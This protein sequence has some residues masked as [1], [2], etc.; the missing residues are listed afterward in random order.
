MA[1]SKLTRQCNWCSSHIYIED[2]KKDITDK[3]V[4]GR[5]HLTMK[6]PTCNEEVEIIVRMVPKAEKKRD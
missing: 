1:F 2:R 3:I 4:D 5:R 6:C